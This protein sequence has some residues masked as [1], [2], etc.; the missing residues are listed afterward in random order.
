[1]RDFTTTLQR[2][3]YK[4]RIYSTA[5]ISGVIVK[6]PLVAHQLAGLGDVAALLG[7]LQQGQFSSWYS[8]LAQSFGFLL[9]SWNLNNPNLPRRSGWLRRGLRSYALTSTTRRLSEKY[10]SA[11]RRRRA[12]VPNATS[13]ADRIEQAASR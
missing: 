5:R 6:Q 12:M 9:S 11:S 10:E 1:M 7:E 2:R 4:C 8:E 13:T 3:L